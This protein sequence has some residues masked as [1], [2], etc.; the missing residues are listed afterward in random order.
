MLTVVSHDKFL[1]ALINASDDYKRYVSRAGVVH[2]FLIQK[3]SDHATFRLRINE[4]L[5]KIRRRHKNEYSI[6]IK[7]DTCAM[8]LWIRDSRRKIE[9]LLKENGEEILQPLFLE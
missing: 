9:T 8:I 2:C 7:R 5:G 1:N 4:V 3:T 6:L